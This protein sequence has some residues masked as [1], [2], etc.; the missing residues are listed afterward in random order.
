[1]YILLILLIYLA[2]I[3]LG[4]PDSLLGSGWPV[5]HIQF[6]VPLSSAGIVAMLISGGTIISSLMSAK[7]T[8]RLG[9]GLI[10]TLSVFIT[11]LALF[12]FSI[13]T[14][15][16]MLCIWAI[17]YGLGAG[18]IDA[19][20]NNYVAL[21]YSSRH[22]NW[23]HCFWGVGTIISPYIMSYFLTQNSD[24]NGGYK[25]VSFI[26]IAITLILL[27]CLP[28]W[29]KAHPITYHDEKKSNTLSLKEA[30]KIKGVKEIL[31]GFFSYCAAEGTVMLWVSSYLVEA[32]KI[33]A[34][35]AA[36]FASFFFIGIT[37]GR[38]ISGI[39]SNKISDKK[40]IQIGTGI[41]ILGIIFISIPVKISTPA[42]LGFVIMGLGCAP[43]YPAI[44]HSTP[45]NF[46]KENSQSIIGIQMASAYVGSTFIPPIFGLIAN[47]IN[48]NLLS[49]FLMFFVVLMF[50]MTQKVNKY[51]Q[52]EQ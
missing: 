5:M 12:G 23:L 40:L 52:T 1:M 18:A 27:I 33:T 6:D 48:I 21:H 16:Y 9:T 31:I 15:F 17:P 44:I 34:E 4:L 41:I 20:L 24:W 7:I 46:G 29:K 2:F 8:K 26:Q 22:M 36:A 42:L 47:Y 10:T 45:K 38:F 3:S 25:F 51:T 39:I 13:S 50:I 49:I 14:H 28:L 37:V 43:I 19:A 30:F 32:K 35:T 11:A